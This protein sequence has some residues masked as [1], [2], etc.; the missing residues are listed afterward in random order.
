VILWPLIEQLWEARATTT[1]AGTVLSAYVFHRRG[2]AISRGAFMKRWKKACADAKLPGKLFHDFRRTAA[3]NM[4]RAGVPETV[5]M[6]VTGHKTRSMLDRYSITNGADQLEALRR[7]REF[8]AAKTET[9]SAQVIS[10][11]TS[12]PGA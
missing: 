11:P 2:R 5:A 4:I 9:E 8:V 6:K 3:R 7:S 10:H 1:A 12:H